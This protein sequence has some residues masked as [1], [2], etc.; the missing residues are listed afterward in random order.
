MHIGA[1]DLRRLGSSSVSPLAGRV[2]IQI[3]VEVVLAPAGDV[4][5]VLKVEVHGDLDDPMSV[6]AR[7]N[8]IDSTECTSRG[9]RSPT[10]RRDG[11]MSVALRGVR[12]TGAHH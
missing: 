6:Y 10:E 3:L 2:K 12:R 9:L 7:K 11:Q 8:E 1:N 5:R 4:V